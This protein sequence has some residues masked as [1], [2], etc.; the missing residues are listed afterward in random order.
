MNVDDLIGLMPTSLAEVS[1]LSAGTWTLAAALLLALLAAFLANGVL[2][3]TYALP[4][5]RRDAAARRAAYDHDLRTMQAMNAAHDYAYMFTFLGALVG[6]P[7]AYD[8]GATVWYLS[9]GLDV[10]VDVQDPLWWA[11][12]APLALAGIV[13]VAVLR[14]ETAYYGFR[15][16]L[17]TAPLSVSL[18]LGFLALGFVAAPAVIALILLHGESRDRMLNSL[19]AE[20]EALRTG[21]I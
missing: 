1:Y 3:R 17:V 21:N 9:R 11:V 15:Q 13:A 5:A 8:A 18:Y 6:L 14:R 2:A 12:Y 16:A 10:I 20:F 7:F 4:A 19:G